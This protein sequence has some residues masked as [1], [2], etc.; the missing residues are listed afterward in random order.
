MFSHLAELY[1]KGLADLFR[2]AAYQIPHD[3]QRIY[4][5]GEYDL[6]PACIFNS[7]SEDTEK[8]RALYTK[9]RVVRIPAARY[10][11]A[12]IT[13]TEGANGEGQISA[14]IF[15]PDQTRIYLQPLDSKHSIDYSELRSMT[16]EE[17][18]KSP[19]RSILYSTLK[20]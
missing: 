16:S 10:I 7:G 19:S 4:L 11:F 14:S 1:V 9:R 6:Q 12:S 5:T 20:T 18:A 8:N 17:I 2:I 15:Q 3:F 13:A